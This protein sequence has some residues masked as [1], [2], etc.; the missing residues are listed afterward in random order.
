MHRVST[1][2]NGKRSMESLS[3]KIMFVPRTYLTVCSIYFQKGSHL[4]VS[5]F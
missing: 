3:R 4:Y 5:Q 1:G 2:S